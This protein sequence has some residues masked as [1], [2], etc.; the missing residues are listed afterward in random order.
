MTL[1]EITFLPQNIA[2]GLFSLIS[3]CDSNRI[4]SKGFVDSVA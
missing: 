3:V 2:S 4:K 1:E